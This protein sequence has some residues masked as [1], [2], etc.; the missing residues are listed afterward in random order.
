NKAK[1]IAIEK[2]DLF[3]M[4][5]D[6][7]NVFDKII[8]S[9]SYIIFE[10]ENYFEE[11]KVN[12]D[13]IIEIMMIWIRDVSFVRNNIEHLVIN[14]DYLSLANIH[15]GGMKTDDVD[16]LIQYL[17]SVSENIKNNVNYKLA[18]DKMV[19]KIQEV[20]KI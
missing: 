20:F 15:A 3:I 14:K 7:I 17:Q 11:K 10:C 13:I 6:I 12:I 4:R 9:D 2:D 18:V 19:F 5:S 1:N 16:E 8:K